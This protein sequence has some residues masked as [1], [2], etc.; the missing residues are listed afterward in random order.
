MH[1]LGELR[2]GVVTKGRNDPVAAKSLAT[3]V[4]SIEFSF[5]DR[6]VGIDAAIARLWG[7][8]SGDRLKAMVDTLLALRRRSMG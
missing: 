6:P 7:D 8:W 2:K 5:A 4:D 3:S 1:V